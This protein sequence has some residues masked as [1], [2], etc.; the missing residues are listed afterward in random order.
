MQQKK[1]VFKGFL[2]SAGLAEFEEKTE[3][4]KQL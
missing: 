2:E 3:V 4:T 1:G